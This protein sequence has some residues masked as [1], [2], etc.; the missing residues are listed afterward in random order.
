MPKDADG[1]RYLR[2]SQAA[3][4]FH[5]SPKTLQRW[6]AEGK[7][8]YL[9]TLGGHRRYR[10]SDIRK[11]VEELTYRPSPAGVRRLHP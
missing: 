10:E 11:L 1:D 5:V 3:A 8:S 7:L 2:A 4:I 6:S 9:S